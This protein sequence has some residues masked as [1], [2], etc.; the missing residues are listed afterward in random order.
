MNNRVLI[1]GITGMDGSNLADLLVEKEYEVYGVVRRASTINT[2]RIDHLLKK[3]KITLMF[4]DLSDGIDDI[5][6]QIKPHMLFNLASM[7]QVRVS[8]DI[9]KYTLDI[10]AI[11]PSRILEC[12]RRNNLDTRIYQASSSELFGISPSPQNENTVFRPCSPYGIAKLAAYWMFR[13]YRDGYGLFASN[14]ILFNHESARRGMTFVTQK[15]VYAAVK[16]KLGMIDTVEFGNLESRRDFGSSK[17]Y[18]E[19]MLLILQHSVPD[20]FV[21]ATGENY[22]IREFVEKVFNKIGLNWEEYV[23][24]DI[25]RYKR[26]KEVPDLLG[27]PTKIKKVLGWEH[28]T[29]IDMLIDEMLEGAFRNIREGTFC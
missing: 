29:N 7:S 18:V 2:S 21:V 19:A 22:S 20:D 6:L 12:V 27:D 23:V 5:I 10:N 3:D 24:Y 9:P 15:A 16:I 4:G 11:G 1:T 8:F 14:G 17:D 26:P 28:K 25:E 13:T